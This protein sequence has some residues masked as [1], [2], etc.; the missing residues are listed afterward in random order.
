MKNDQM[1]EKVNNRN[2]NRSAKR[3]KRKKEEENREKGEKWPQKKIRFREPTRRFPKA[4]AFPKWASLCVLVRS[5]CFSEAATIA[6]S[7][8]INIRVSSPKHHRHH[9]E[10]LPTIHNPSS[11]PTG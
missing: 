6:W 5:L 4:G 7:Q 3:K 1:K 10:T 9:F 8:P 2:R 11:C